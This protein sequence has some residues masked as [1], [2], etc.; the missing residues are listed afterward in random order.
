LSGLEQEAGR[1][2]HGT[3]RE[4]ERKKRHGLLQ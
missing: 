2:R 3:D 4:V 1:S